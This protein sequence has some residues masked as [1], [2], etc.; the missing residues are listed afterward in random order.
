MSQIQEVERLRTVGEV[1]ADVISYLTLRKA[2]GVLGMLLPWVVVFGAKVFGSYAM[3][4]SIS[5][6]YYSNMQD[7]FVGLL[8][9]VG[10]FLFAYKGF[11]RTDDVVANVCGLLAMAVAIFP[12]RTEDDKRLPVGIFQA[13]DYVSSFVHYTCAV[14]LFVLLASM[15]LF[16][17]RKTTEGATP[18]AQKLKR[19]KVYFGCGVFMYAAVVVGGLLSL[20]AFDRLTEHAHVI[21]W[22]E[23]LCLSAFG[24]SWLVKGEALMADEKA[25]AS[26]SNGQPALQ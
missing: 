14:L 2:V 16:L 9:M 12:T 17:F 10:A 4:D 24:F 13:N 1:P 8:I 25:L 19:N 5:A 18:T 23:A 20:P 22:V 7:L 6:Y 21:F 11:S 26:A 3:K 15:S